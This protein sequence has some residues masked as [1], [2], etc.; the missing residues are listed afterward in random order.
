MCLNWRFLNIQLDSPVCVYFL[1]NYEKCTFSK[2][3]MQNGLVN[4]FT[5]DTYLND[6]FDVTNISFSLVCLPAESVSIDD[7]RPWWKVN[8]HGS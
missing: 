6:F 1:E 5:A 4:S 7:R 3:R 8:G 2:N